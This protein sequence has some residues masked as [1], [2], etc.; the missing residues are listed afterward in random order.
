MT[1]RGDEPVFALIDFG[2]AV[3]T[4]TWPHE[5]RSRN[6][7]GTPHYFA[8]STWMLLACGHKYLESHPEFGY[9]RQYKERLDHFALGLLSLELLFCLWHGADGP[10][11]EDRVMVDAF[12]KARTVW[13]TYWSQALW[14][15][16]QFFAKGPNKLRQVLACGPLAQL[17]ESLRALIAELRV[18][19]AAGI[20]TA[21]GPVLAVAAELLDCNS[22]LTW[23]DVPRTLRPPEV[24]TRTA[25]TSTKAAVRK[26]N[27]RRVWTVDES[28]SRDVPDL[29]SA[30]SGS[31]DI[32]KVPCSVR[33]LAPR[34]PPTL[35]LGP[36]TSAPFL[37]V[38]LQRSTD[39]S[40]DRVAVAV[41][42][43]LDL[44]V[45]PTLAEER[46]PKDDNDEAA[47]NNARC[48]APVGAADARDGSDGAVLRVWHPVI[49]TPPAVEDSVAGGRPAASIPAIDTPTPCCWPRLRH[50]SRLVRKLR[51]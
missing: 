35:A 38:H 5:Y 48:I 25:C 46:T 13:R 20:D 12:G 15:Y 44:E 14:L 37:P 22:A 26:F 49:A 32:N 39:S 28:L 41:A 4:H 6:L 30:P 16:Q 18:A 27:H 11:P 8:P 31:Q 19:A 29:S 9:L 17:V 45:C 2:L 34:S 33:Q 47:E 43:G 50:L 42:S 23:A 36:R 1:L 10:A 24:A 3:K 51:R 7:A 21:A 40:L